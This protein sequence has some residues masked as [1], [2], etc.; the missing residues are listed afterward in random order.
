[1]L[2][3]EP[4]CCRLPALAGREGVLLAAVVGRVLALP[5][6]DGRCDRHVLSLVVELCAWGA[7][8]C[9][10]VYMAAGWLLGASLCSWSSCF[11]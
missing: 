2:D 3:P 7:S 6:L 4:W 1:M 11:S 5:L 9:C 8:S 10:P